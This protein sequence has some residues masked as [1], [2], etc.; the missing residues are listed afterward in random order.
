M[1]DDY[2]LHFAMMEK[3]VRDKSNPLT[4]DEIRD[5]LNM[6]LE[7]LTEKQN[8]ESENDNNQ[9]VLFFGCQFKRKCRNCGL[10]GHKAKECKLKFNQNDGHNGG[11]HNN[12]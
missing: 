2:D 11:N 8:E 1:T 12:F 4:V 3:R 5:D 9:E 7:R 6:R 10:I